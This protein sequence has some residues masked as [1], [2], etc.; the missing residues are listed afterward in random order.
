MTIVLVTDDVKVA[1]QTE[2]ALFMVDGEIVGE[3]HLGEY[4]KEKTIL[5]KTKNNYRLG[6]LKWGYKSK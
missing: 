1:A 6:F 2:R 3:Q 4:Q 5:Q